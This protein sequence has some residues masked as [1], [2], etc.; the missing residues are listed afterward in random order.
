MS[1]SQFRGKRIKTYHPTKGEARRAK[2]QRTAGA[3]PTSREPFGRGLV[4]RGLV[5]RSSTRPANGI[6][7]VRQTCRCSKGQ[8]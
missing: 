7:G 4:Q 2:A 5:T 6:W 1:R 3:R 8:T